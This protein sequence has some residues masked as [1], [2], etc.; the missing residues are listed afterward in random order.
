MAVSPALSTTLQCVGW[1]W[2]VLARSSDGMSFAND[3]MASLPEAHRKAS[4]RSHALDHF[5]A[6]QRL[7]ELSRLN[8]LLT[9]SLHSP[10]S[11]WRRLLLQAADLAD[12][13]ARI[14]ADR[15]V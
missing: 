3:I 6:I 1:N 12:A 14:R 2:P 15:V 7:R 9:P 10:M 8:Y 5:T 11:R 13:F 4:G